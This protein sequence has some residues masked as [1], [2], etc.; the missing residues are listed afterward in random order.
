M[1]GQSS[2]AS[3]IFIAYDISKIKQWSSSTVIELYSPSATDS[4]FKE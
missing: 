3:S 2:I 4:I 1:H